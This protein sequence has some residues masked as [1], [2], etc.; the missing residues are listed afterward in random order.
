MKITEMVKTVKSIAGRDGLAGVRNAVLAYINLKC[1]PLNMSSYPLMLQIEPTTHCNLECTMCANPISRRKKH[2]MSFEDF[3]RIIDRAP[4]LKKVSLVGAGEPLMN[5]AIFDMISYARSK[6]IAIGFATNGMLLS[7]ASY[8]NMCAKLIEAGSDW[9][10]ISIDSAD[11]AKYENIRR[12]ASLDF[13]TNNIKR[14]VEARGKNERPDISIWFVIMENNVSDLTGVV[15][16]AKD[17]GIGKV[18][19]QLEH[20]WNEE[21][22]RIRIGANRQSF[23][24]EVKASLKEAL[25][26]AKEIGVDFDYVNVPAPGK[27]SCKWPWKSAYISA[28]GFVTPCCLQGSNPEVINF[29][30]AVKN[31]LKSIW[32]NDKYKKFRAALKAESMPAICR[33]CTSYYERMKI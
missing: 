6:G 8:R 33:G 25:S 7:D 3:K 22:L 13:V 31:D 29:G 27:R 15:K 16:L 21:E 30:S 26:L 18:S 28:E 23:A 2:H 5:P 4:F 11:R 17:L 24:V 1:E 9:L 32:N 10:N 20:S 12:G 19:A 14:L